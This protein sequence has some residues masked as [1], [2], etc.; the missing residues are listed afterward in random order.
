MGG[1]A[2]RF[3]GLGEGL[4]RV[5]GLDRNS[6]KRNMCVF[7]CFSQFYLIFSTSINSFRLRQRS[8]NG[9]KWREEEKEVRR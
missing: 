7:F 2:G 5:S 3:R 9:G 1:D 8:L 4:G 6:I